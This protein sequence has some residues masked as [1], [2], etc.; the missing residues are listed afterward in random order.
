MK[1]AIVTIEIPKGSNN[2]YSVDP[3]T[4]RVHLKRELAASLAYPADY[5]FIEGTRTEEGDHLAAFVLLRNPIFP[6]VS[7]DTRVVGSLLTE[8]MG[9]TDMKVITVPANDPR[10]KEIR[11][12]KDVPGDLR[13]RM[14]FFLKHDKDFSPAPHRVVVSWGDFDYTR[15]IVDVAQLR[16]DSQ[17]NGAK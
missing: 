10:W 1:L 13:A 3:L 11:D 4:G 5:G 14:E 12:I 9:R 6:G 15:T 16:F 8:D 17:F 7:I 2:K